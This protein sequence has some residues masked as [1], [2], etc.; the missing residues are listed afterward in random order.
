MHTLGVRRMRRHRPPLH[1]SR[2]AL[3]SRRPAG[4]RR[5]R[6]ASGGSEG[7]RLTGGAGDD[8]VAYAEAPRVIVNLDAGLGGSA[9]PGD[10]DQV[11]EIE[12]VKGGRRGDTVTG[13]TSANRL[14]G[15]DGHDY[16][17]GRQGVD[18]LDGGASADVVAARDG[19][20][21]LPISCG[22]GRDFAIVDR[23]D[24]V[25]RRGRNACEQVDDG[26]RSTPR[27]RQ[28]YI[29]A[30]PCASAGG[31]AAF[32]LP[33]MKRPVP[34]R[35]SIMVRTGDRRRSAPGLE[36]ADCTLGLRAALGR[37]RSASA[38][39]SGDAVTVAQAG[40]RKLMTTLSVERPVCVTGARSRETQ[41]VASRVRLRA[42][43]GHRG[44]WRVQGRYSIGASRGT[45]W[46]TVEGCSSTTTVVRR[47]RVRIFDRVRRR[48]VTVGPGRSY[49]ARARRPSR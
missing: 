16:L 32:E 11:A 8:A 9:E 5:C 37:S 31:A 36:P 18:Q 39:L 4:R 26:S 34:L 17:D 30:P 28:L 24:T 41:A 49:V 47:G 7:D 19:A 44:R 2:V 22:P 25:L 6:A 43:G 15:A 42:R 33:A 27:A 40:S 29:H 48:T 10:S 3:A 23:R 1:P 35:Y 38:D 14:T 45:D 12:D 13:S 46:T 21:D 20:R